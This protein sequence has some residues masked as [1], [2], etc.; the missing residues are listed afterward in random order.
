M[1]SRLPCPARWPRLRRQGRRQGAFP[2]PLVFALEDQPA[3]E[4]PA[5]AVLEH[6]REDV[7]VLCRDLWHLKLKAI[8]AAGAVPV[9]VLLREG[10]ERAD[11]G[12]G[13]AIA[14]RV[15][16]LVVAEEL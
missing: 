15:G 14:A 9:L 1:T 5:V 6:S 12:I 10:Q 3:E 7:A 16:A 11:P 2:G 4:A 8:G 13:Q